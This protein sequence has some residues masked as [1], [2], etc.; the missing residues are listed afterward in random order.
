MRQLRHA[1]Q[2]VGGRRPFRPFGLLADLGDAAPAHAFFAD[3]DAVAI[4]LALVLHEIEEFAVGIDDDRARRFL[5]GIVDDMAE[6]TFARLVIEIRRAREQL[7]VARLQRRIRQSDRACRKGSPQSESAIATKASFFN[8]MSS[9]SLS[10]RPPG[11]QRI[12]LDT[13]SRPSLEAVKC[14][15]RRI[16]KTCCRNT[17]AYIDRLMPIFRERYGHASSSRHLNIKFS[18]IGHKWP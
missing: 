10:F 16:A 4:G 13:Q 17:A 3:G 2:N 8:S 5:A 18:E 9:S 11:T 15:I 6:P 7:L 1:L 14:P 12:A